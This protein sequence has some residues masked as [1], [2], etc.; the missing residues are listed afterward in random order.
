MNPIHRIGIDPRWEKSWKSIRKTNLEADKRRLA[1][2]LIPALEHYTS[3]GAGMRPI[4]DGA[5][6]QDIKPDHRDTVNNWEQYL[7][8]D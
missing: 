7:A 4:V 8:T 5:Q 3:T 2:D 1:Q 6:V